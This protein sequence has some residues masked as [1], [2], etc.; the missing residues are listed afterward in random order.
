MG[1]LCFVLAL[2]AI[3]IATAYKI[4]EKKIVENGS[5][6]A[7]WIRFGG[8][9]VK[10][11]LPDTKYKR[12]DEKYRYVAIKTLDYQPFIK[13]KPTDGYGF[14]SECS[15]TYLVR[16]VKYTGRSEP[17]EVYFD[18]GDLVVFQ[19]VLTE[20][21]LMTEKSPLLVCPPDTI[22]NVFPMVTAVE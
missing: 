1:R 11:R 16:S 7:H 22:R 20:K 6:G 14:L 10:K 18:G 15:N 12:V 2:I 17:I 19:G 5:G 4:I 9:K 3:M 8:E 21:A 13:I